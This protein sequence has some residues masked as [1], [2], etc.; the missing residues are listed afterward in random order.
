VPGLTTALL[1]IFAGVALVVTLAGLAGLVGTSVSQ[2][3]REFGLRMALG[4]TRGSVLRLV[5]RQGIV[6]VIAGV[7][8]GIGG[9]YAFSQLIGRFL[10][11]TRPTDPM[12]Y[13]IVACVF[14]A[15]AL[16]AAFAPARRATR[17]DPLV[18]LRS[19]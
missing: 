13:A 11:E 5:L 14:A 7:A 4:A 8:L 1:G 16:A 2:R 12:A 10:F 3:T 6:L 15:A 9:A 18:A 17:I 19:E